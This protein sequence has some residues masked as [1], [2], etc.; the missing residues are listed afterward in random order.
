MGMVLTGSKLRYCAT[1]VAS[2][3][4]SVCSLQP[5]SDKKDVDQPLLSVCSI[6]RLCGG[7]MVGYQCLLHP[8]WDSSVRLQ[9]LGLTTAQVCWKRKVSSTTA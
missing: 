5:K 4:G 9:R 2:A 3:D 6:V 8:A 7:D 1:E